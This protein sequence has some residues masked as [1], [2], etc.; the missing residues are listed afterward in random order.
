MIELSTEIKTQQINEAITDKKNIKIHACDVSQLAQV[1]EVIGSIKTTNIL[2][3]NAGIT[4]IGN[5]ENTNETD[6]ERIFNVNV[7][8]VYHCMHNCIPKMKTK[9]G[10]VIVN[11]ASVASSRDYPINGG[12]IYLNN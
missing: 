6:F 8:G 9:S 7:K 5:A 4:R 12:F 3:N 1:E 2:V 10:N 11:M